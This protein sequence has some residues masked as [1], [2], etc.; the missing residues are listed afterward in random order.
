MKY[1]NEFLKYEIIIN[2]SELINFI[3]NNINFVYEINKI[4][5]K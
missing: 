3:L 1:E 5:M 4:I 2:F